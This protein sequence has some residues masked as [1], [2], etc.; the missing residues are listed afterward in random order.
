MEQRLQFAFCPCGRDIR[1]CGILCG[2]ELGRTVAFTL[3]VSGLFSSIILID[4]DSRRGELLATDLSHTPSRNH[5]TEVFLGNHADL[6]DCGIIVVAREDLIS[7]VSKSEPERIWISPALERAARSISLYNRDAI[8]IVASE[9]VDICAYLF[10]R[11]TGFPSERV[12]GTGT[13]P[14]TTRLE[15]M[16]GRHLGVDD[17]GVNAFIIG[18][19]GSHALPVW[20][21]ANVCGLDLRH[22]CDCCG[23]GYEH[24]VADSLFEDVR[25]CAC[26]LT[27]SHSGTFAVARAVERIAQAVV[28]EENAVLTVCTMMNGQYGIEDIC[29]SLPCVVGRHGIRQVLDIPLNDRE[30]A[31]FRHAAQSL[32]QCLSQEI[33]LR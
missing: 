29:L 11:H 20:S 14:D 18:E 2:G 23:R 25:E 1:K 8:L 13:L 17:R 19:R 5:T 32:R 4:T 16:L 30:E 9:P 6:S 27:G 31:A 28:R 22:F 24:T 7:P 3:T 26:R 10:Q 21:L 12:I 33:S 15:Q